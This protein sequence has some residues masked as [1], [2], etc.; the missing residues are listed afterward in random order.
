MS[1]DEYEVIEIEVPLFGMFLEVFLSDY[2]KI[3]DWVKE[4]F[5]CDL[6]NLDEDVV[7][8]DGFTVNLGDA[9]T[10]GY[11]VI[12]LK[13]FRRKLKRKHNIAVG[14]LTHE[15][16]HAVKAIFESRGIPFTP[17]N[18]EVIAYA[19]EHLVESVLNELS[20]KKKEN[21]K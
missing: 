5:D 6:S 12:A 7:N 16:L 10:D 2:S 13:D 9:G 19:Q 8:A 17:E 15:C 3:Y 11:I 18:E 21:R 20:N 14:V 1:R 4:E